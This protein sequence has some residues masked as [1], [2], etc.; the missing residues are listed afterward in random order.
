[1]PFSISSA[2]EVWQRKMH[3]AIEGLWAVI[4]A[5]DFLMCGFGDTV[6][7]AVLDH[8][9]NLTAFLERCCKLN[10]TLNHHKVKLG[11]SEVPFMGYLLTADGIEIEE[12]Y[13]N[14][15]LNCGI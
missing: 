9:Q 10:L 15:I 8:N 5:N 3:E 7:S 13:E 4:I 14:H 11:L 6:A 12:I 1:M 2:P